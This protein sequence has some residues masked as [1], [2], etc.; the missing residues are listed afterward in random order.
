[1]GIFHQIFLFTFATTDWLATCVKKHRNTIWSARVWTKAAII[2]AYDVERD[3]DAS[4]I[5][6]LDDE[7]LRAIEHVEHEKEGDEGRH[8][9][10]E[11]DLDVEKYTVNGKRNFHAGRSEGNGTL[12]GAGETEVVGSKKHESTLSVWMGPEGHACGEQ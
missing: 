11:I 6:A 1:M 5:T 9:P 7:A 4:D 12:Q 3:A 10:S 2:Y 8:V